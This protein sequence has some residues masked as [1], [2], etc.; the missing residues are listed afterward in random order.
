M[1]KELEAL[2]NIKIDMEYVTRLDFVEPIVRGEVQQ[3]LYKIYHR[4]TPELEIIEKALKEYER[5]KII[6]QAETRGFYF[7][8][9]QNNNEI[10]FSGNSFI[11]VGNHFVQTKPC[12]EVKETTLYSC[13]NPLGYPSPS[14][15]VEDAH[16]W[17][18]KTHL[19]FRIDEHGKTWALTREELEK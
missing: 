5:L 1:S 13:Y 6:E 11:R 19:H 3:S 7:K 12:Y 9:Y 14:V 17:S 2:E 10:R 15:K 16:F 4:E 18:W 8:D